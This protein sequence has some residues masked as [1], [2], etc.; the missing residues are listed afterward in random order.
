[1]KIALVI[2]IMVSAVLAFFCLKFLLYMIVFLIK[3]KNGKK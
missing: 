3:G 2:G 1:M